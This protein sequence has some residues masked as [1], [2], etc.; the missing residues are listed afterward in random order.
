MAGGKKGIIGQNPQSPSPSTRGPQGS[1]GDAASPDTPHWFIGET[2]GPNGQNDASDP[3][4]QMGRLRTGPLIIVRWTP[5]VI[6]EYQ[7]WVKDNAE[8]YAASGEE[9]DCA[10]WAI[11]ML[12]RFARPR[13]LPVR[14]H[15]GGSG[16]LGG[17]RQQLTGGREMFVGGLLDPQHPGSG[18]SYAYS[19]W[20]IIENFARKE[21]GARDL[22]LSGFDNTVPVVEIANLKSGDMLALAAYHGEDVSRHIQLVLANDSQISIT[23]SKGKS[24]T[25]PVLEILQGDLPAAVIRR[26]AWDLKDA[27][28]Y[29]FVSGKWVTEE[30]DAPGHIGT[31][32][33]K[34]V[35]GRRWNFYWFND[36]AAGVIEVFK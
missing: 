2:S 15:K 21:I 35:F 28:Y 29:R 20:D 36:T 16:E 9:F 31:L 1:N 32:W 12:I 7:Q 26:A 19:P 17:L 24:E 27:R 5:R 4:T 23:D 34:T 22:L 8:G 14:F 18:N 11:V 30:H 13:E 33:H 6:A 25:R 10:D 3:N